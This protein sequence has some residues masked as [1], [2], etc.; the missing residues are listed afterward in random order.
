M[1]QG[2]VVSISI[3]PSVRE[4]TPLVQQVPR[5]AGPGPMGYRYC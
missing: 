4:P 3:A 2:S 1:W 5:T